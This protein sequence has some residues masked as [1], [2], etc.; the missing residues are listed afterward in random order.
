VADKNSDNFDIELEASIRQT[1]KKPFPVWGWY[2]I[3]GI[4]VVIVIIG[5]VSA[6]RNLTTCPFKIKALVALKAL[7]NVELAY[8]EYNAEK[9]FATL[10]GLKQEGYVKYGFT[11]SQIA[12]GYRVEITP[13]T[14]FDDEV[15][16]YIIRIFPL[17]TAR[18]CSTFQ[19]GPDRQFREFV[20]RIS[21]DVHE[22]E[23]WIDAS[24]LEEQ[25]PE[26][27]RLDWMG[28]NYAYN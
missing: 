6:D 13:F 23:N 10:D 17:N 9:V 21:S 4:I 1:K 15:Q 7:G 8:Q 26:R 18:P 3:A 28:D 22:P 11:E 20:P 5:I 14:M 24:Y 12:P 25:L 27:E 19:M 16:S 2:V